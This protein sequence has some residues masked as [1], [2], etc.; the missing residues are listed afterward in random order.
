M[1]ISKEQNRAFTFLPLPQF[2]KWVSKNSV[3]DMAKG[4]NSY[5][6]NSEGK[7]ISRTEA[8]FQVFGL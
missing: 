8:I 6:E 1:K 4:V 5:S 2:C 3:L 7:Q